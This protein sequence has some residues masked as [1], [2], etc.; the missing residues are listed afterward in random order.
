MFF[1]SLSSLK[2]L[3]SSRPC[4]TGFH[5]SGNEIGSAEVEVEAIFPDQWC[6]DGYKRLECR[7]YLV[8]I[9]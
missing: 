8:P 7:D 6:C 4:V 3:L 2:K 5:F 1:F 9:L